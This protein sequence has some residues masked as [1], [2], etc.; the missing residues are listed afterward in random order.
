MSGDAANTAPS[1]QSAAVDAALGAETIASEAKLAEL[2]S[3]VQ[4]ANDR[5]LRAQAELDNARK[6]MKREFDEERK[7]QLL[8]LVRDL[9]SVADN[10]ERALAGSAN[11]GYVGDLV[12]EWL[13]HPLDFVQQRGR[14]G[15]G[16]RQVW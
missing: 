16:Q 8:P 5:A 15:V 7:Y 4:E 6:R 13:P 3:Q 10:L 9:L 14:R 12:A 11:V 2:A 1:D